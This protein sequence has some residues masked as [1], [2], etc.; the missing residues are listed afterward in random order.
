M[1]TKKNNI[2]QRRAGRRVKGE[3]RD[4][5]RWEPD[6]NDRRTGHGRRAGDGP[7]KPR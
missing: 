5:V 1:T 3:R 6:K 7:R 4:V 2:E